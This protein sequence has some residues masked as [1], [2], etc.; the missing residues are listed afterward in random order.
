MKERIVIIF[1]AVTLGLLV[2]TIGFF[3]YETSKPNKDIKPDITKKE[4]TGPLP[5]EKTKLTILAP[6]DETVTTNRTIQVKGVTDPQN[7]LIISTNTEDVVV[8]PT[9]EGSF[10]A[11]IT[12]DAGEN[13]LVVRAIDPS[14]NTEEVIQTIS[15]SSDTL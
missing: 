7:T 3:L 6:K 13:K 8:G 4:K 14:G 12:I 5:S 11:T 9:S 15:F 10:T 1:I 2:T